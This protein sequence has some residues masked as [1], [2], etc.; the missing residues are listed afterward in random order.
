M[1]WDFGREF[2][3]GYSGLF[4]FCFLFSLVRCGTREDTK[5][6]FA[7]KGGDHFTPLRFRPSYHRFYFIFFSLG[8]SVHCSDIAWSKEILFLLFYFPLFLFNL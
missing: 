7:T 3:F 8:N 2:G 6:W 4:L 5:V 1:R